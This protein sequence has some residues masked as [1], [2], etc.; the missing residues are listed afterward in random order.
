VLRAANRFGQIQ[1]FKFDCRLPGWPAAA[2]EASRRAPARTRLSSV[3]TDDRH[4]RRR[5]TDRKLVALPPHTHTYVNVAPNP[6]LRPGRSLVVP[7]SRAVCSHDRAG[8]SR[9]DGICAGEVCARPALIGGRRSGALSAASG[10][11]LSNEQ[12]VRKKWKSQQVG[13]PSGRPNERPSTRLK[14]PASAGGQNHPASLIQTSALARPAAY[15]VIS[16]QNIGR[17]RPRLCV[18]V[19]VCVCVLFWCRLAGACG[20]GRLAAGRLGSLANLPL[21]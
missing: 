10:K 13:R 3:A 6:T 15:L 7:I 16:D 11:R 19:C 17:R 18:C 1:R 21:D 9:L 14:S 12:N 20:R 4:R 2:A 8:R 5:R